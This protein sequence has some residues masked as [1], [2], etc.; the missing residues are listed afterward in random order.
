MVAKENKIKKVWK[1][2]NK[3]KSGSSPIIAFFCSLKL[4]IFLLITLAAVSIIGTIIPQNE[5]KEQYLRFYQESTYDIMK[6][7]G[8]LDM[9]H[10]W[11]FRGILILFTI[12]LIVCSFKHFPRIWKFFKSPVTTLSDSFLAT[13]TLDWKT[14]ISAKNIAQDKSYGDFLAEKLSAFWSGSWLQTK[15]EG[16]FG[17]ELHFFAQRGL[18]SRM[19]VYLVHLSIIFIF[20]G[21]IVGSH[22]G[23]KAFVNIPEGDKTSIVYTRND[24]RTPVDLG[25]TVECQAF[26]VEFYDS[27][28]PKEYTSDLVILEDGKEKVRK[29]IEVNHPLSYQ[30]Y[31]F[32]QSS[33]GSAGGAVK[34]QMHDKKTGKV[35]P[36]SLS[37]GQQ[38]TLPTGDGWIQAAQ[39]ETNYMNLGPAVRLVMPA[40]SDRMIQF[41]IFKKYPGFDQQNRKGDRYFILEDVSQRNYTGLQVTRDPGVWIV[42]F[43]CTMMVFG[44]FIA[45]FISHRRLWVRLRPDPDKTERYQLTV[46]GS[47]NKNKPGFEKEFEHFTSFLEKQLKGKK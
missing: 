35:Y 6:S 46:G 41:W 7:L 27:G 14:R 12:N 19:G 10:S 22:F 37:I 15:K 29:R 13:L 30:G 4:T 44:L 24:E 17:E 36:L 40:G 34:L 25:F 11:W 42:W 5:F 8:V 39:Y 20:I 38:G 28:A 1:V 18:W 32:Y 33:Y 47:A 43:G 2:K 26:N 9:Y 45:F 31:T 3:N 16:D 23:L 21:G